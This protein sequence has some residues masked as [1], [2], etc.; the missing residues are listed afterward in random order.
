MARAKYTKQV[1]VF[2]DEHIY[3]VNADTGEMRSITEMDNNRWDNIPKDTQVFEKSAPFIKFYPK[4]WFFLKGVLSPI[5][6]SAVLSLGMMS[7]ANTCSLEPLGDDSTLKELMAVLGVSI[8]KV[9]PILDKLFDLG[10]FGR[11]EV[12]IPDKPYTKNWILS[13]YIF[14]TGKTIKSDISDL[15]IGTHCERAFRSDNY[16]YLYKVKYSNK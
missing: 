12:H 6:L 8:N 11:F 10:V 7:K 4:T 3:A 2:H 9:K 1:S 15:F 5:E 13:P 14:F 16:L